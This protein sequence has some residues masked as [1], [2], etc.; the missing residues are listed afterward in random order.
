[1]KFG[2]GIINSGVFFLRQL[3]TMTIREPLGILSVVCCTFP[4]LNG[5]VC[6]FGRG[7]EITLPPISSTSPHVLYSFLR[8]AFLVLEF[9]LKHIECRLSISSFFTRVSIEKWHTT[10]GGRDGGNTKTKA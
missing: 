6:L 3:R 4:L 2:L 1:M 5:C 7:A 8:F 10:G 9:P